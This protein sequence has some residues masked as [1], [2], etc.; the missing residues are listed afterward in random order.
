MTHKRTARKLLINITVIILMIFIVIQVLQNSLHDIFEGVSQT[1]PIILAGVSTLGIGF[2]LLE[3]KNMAVIAREMSPSFSWRDGF[4]GYCYIAFYRVLTF[5]TGT[6]ISEVIY[7]RKKE[8]TTAEAVGITSEHMI[9]YKVGVLVWA[10]TGFVLQLGHLYRQSPLIIVLVI[11][12]L[13]MTGGMIF[14]IVFLLNNEAFHRWLIKF[15]DRRVKQTFLHNLFDK[16]NRQITSLRSVIQTSATDKAKLNKVLVLNCLKLVCWYAIPYIT[17]IGSGQRVPFVQSFCLAAIAV[18]VGG[19]IPS[20]AGIG[21]FDLVYVLLFR[22]LTGTVDA[23][24][25]LLL[26]RFAS[27][28]LPFLF[29]IVVA[30][31]M[32]GLAVKNELSELR[33]TQK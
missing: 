30:L 25:S 17:F 2:L 11:Y 20:P 21:S 31:R 12:G 19:T 14:L 13:V 15:F 32:K 26:Y 22:P 9:F 4:A 16:L 28:A 18:A 6:T 29:G 5:G 3:G 33:T 1:K 24:S 7:Y 10:V 8:V 23:I 27:Y